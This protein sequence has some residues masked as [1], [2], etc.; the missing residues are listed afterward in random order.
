MNEE[1]VAM[2]I[3]LASKKIAAHFWGDA[4]T[5][6]G[7]PPLQLHTSFDAVQRL[8]TIGFGASRPKVKTRA[9]DDKRI[10][11]CEDEGGHWASIVIL[12]AGKPNADRS[13]SK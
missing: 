2:D 13:A 12:A 7:Q 1:I 4:G 5:H 8:F 10:A 3:A 9:T 6:E 11:V